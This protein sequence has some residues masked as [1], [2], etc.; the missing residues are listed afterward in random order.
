MHKFIGFILD[1]KDPQTLIKIQKILVEISKHFRKDDFFYVSGCKSEV[2]INEFD[3]YA[4]NYRYLG[5]L[6]KELDEVYQFSQNFS[7]FE[8]TYFLLSD[9]THKESV[10]KRKI[11]RLKKIATLH[12]ISTKNL[13]DGNLDEILDESFVQIEEIFKEMYGAF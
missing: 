9:C 10:I 6:P 2:I 4:L 3:A 1:V 7:Q 11:D 12:I 13:T 5:N 8:L